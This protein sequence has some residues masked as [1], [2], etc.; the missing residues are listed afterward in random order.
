MWLG[1]DLVED[2]QRGTCFHSQAFGAHLRG[3]PVRLCLDF[4]NM[5]LIEQA[6]FPQVGLQPSNRIALTPLVQLGLVAVASRVICGGVRTH[7]VGHCL[8]VG[9]TLSRACVCQGPPHGTQAGEDV[10]AVHADAG[11]AKSGRAPG[12]G[13]SGLQAN[14]L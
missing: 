10:V 6:L 9:R 2:A 8:D 14:R 11:D 12:Q 3:H 7:P 1:V 4:I 13:V 5:R